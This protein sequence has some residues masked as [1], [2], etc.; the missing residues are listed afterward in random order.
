MSENKLKGLELHSEPVQDIIGRPPG[1]MVRSGITMIFIIL[2]L[3]LIG[4]YFIK[5]PEILSATIKINAYNLP[6]QVKARSTGRIDTLFVNDGDAVCTDQPLALI[7]NTAKYSDVL[8]LKEALNDVSHDSAW[9]CDRDLQLGD[10]QNSYL[11]YTQASHAL[12]FFVGNDYL[13]ELIKTKKDQA[14]VLRK[15][16][17]AYEDQLVINTRKLDVET[18]KY[19]ID[20]TLHARGIISK[21]SFNDSR[22][23]Y[24]QQQMSHQS[25]LIEIDN[26]RLNILQAEQNITEM[27]QQRAEQTNNL[28]IQLNVAREQ[29]EANIR[30][31]EQNYFLTSPINGMVAITKY[32]Q[33]NQ[34]IT[35]GETMLTVIP[36]GSSSHFGKIYLSQQ[37]A[38]KVQTGQKVNIKLDDY[39]YM[40]FGFVQV[41]LSG[42]SMVPYEEAGIGNV[43]LLE[44]EMPDSLT[45]QYGI[46]IPYRPEMS[47]TAEIITKD[48]TV[49]DRLLNPIKA[50]VKK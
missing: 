26:I 9:L 4:C 18:E 19:K 14:K 13:G 49:L 1:W 42:I 30:Q 25:Y 27:E 41:K 23:A 31:W 43:F 46:N 50:V 11:N 17:K 24:M 39:P 22:S 6:A 48:L 5:Y 2:A 7:E 8:F 3:L 15:T 33:R 28:V 45:T 38:G 34:N 44:V 29:L 21:T 10:I 47:G 40:E 12:S 16:L 32:W 20:S 35:A 36:Q 37:G